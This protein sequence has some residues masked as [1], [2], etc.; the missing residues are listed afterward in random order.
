[1]NPEQHANLHQTLLAYRGDFLTAL[2]NACVAV[3]KDIEAWRAVV[4]SRFQQK[5][6]QVEELMSGPYNRE[7]T[8]DWVDDGREYY[9][10][11]EF[12]KERRVR[13]RDDPALEI[14][15]VEYFEK[16]ARGNVSVLK[17]L[18]DAGY[19]TPPQNKFFQD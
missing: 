1:M 9:D 18:Q 15:A 10:I 13:L 16:Y 3:N 5:F 14:S 12:I 4:E 7:L 17:V 19:F 8:W 6:N 11:S 2:E